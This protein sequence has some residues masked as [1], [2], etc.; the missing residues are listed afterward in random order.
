VIRS[1]RR[2]ETE[3]KPTPQDRSQPSGLVA[4]IPLKGGGAQ[5]G[6][7]TE[8]AREQKPPNVTYEVI[9]RMDN[10]SFRVVMQADAEGLR[11]GDKVRVDEGKVVLR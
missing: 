8:I 6:S 9:V 10:G 1:V 3:V 2:V 5:V 4:T 7:S 11:A